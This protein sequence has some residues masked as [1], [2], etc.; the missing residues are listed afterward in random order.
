[1][2][3]EPFTDRLLRHRRDPQSLDGLRRLRARCGAAEDRL[4][5]IGEDELAF[6][7]ASHAWMILSMS[8]R[9]SRV[10]ISFSCFFDLA[11]RGT[12]LKPS[13]GTIGR[14]AIFHFFHFSSY[15]SGSAS[16]TRWPTAHV[17]T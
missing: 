15:S 11:S 6:A 14:S 1:E 12:S 9:F 2:L 16:W 8:S 17:I 5:H 13:G 3:L 7:P 4:V 10:S